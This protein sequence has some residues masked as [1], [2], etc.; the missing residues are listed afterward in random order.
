MESLCN[1]Q[2]LWR[3]PQFCDTCNLHRHTLV[4]LQILT[5]LTVIS[6]TFYAYQILLHQRTS[7]RHLHL[8]MK[9]RSYAPHKAYA[10]CFKESHR[11]I[12][13]PLTINLTCKSP[14]AEYKAVAHLLVWLSI[15]NSYVE[16]IS[17]W[18]TCKDYFTYP[19]LHQ[20]CQDCWH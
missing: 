12:S 20:L 19:C 14:K 10:M 1:T 16:Q 3:F 18:D 4:L 2:V 9:R 13:P 15:S 7:M 11:R 17:H 5:T 8:R 6:P